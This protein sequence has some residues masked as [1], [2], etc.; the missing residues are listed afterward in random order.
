[1][2]PLTYVDDCIIIGPSKT[3]IYL[4]ITSMQN[5]PEKFKLMDE[6][7]DNK[8]P[9][10]KIIRPNDITFKLSQL[11]LFDQ[12]LSFLYLSNNKFA[13]KANL[14]NFHCKGSS[15]LGSIR[16][17]AQILLELSQQWASCLT[18]RTLLAMRSS[19]LHTKP[20]TSST[21]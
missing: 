18:Y 5:R 4:L 11:F 19:W 8:F 17:A 10:I 9:G 21:I 14:I 16:E 3:S 15:S 13:T 12:I 6:E 2:V 20:P 1:M 7:D